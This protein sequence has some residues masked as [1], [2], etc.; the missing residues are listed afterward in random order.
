MGIQLANAARLAMEALARVFEPPPPVDYLAWAE[1][2]IVFSERESPFPGP[3]NVSLFPHVTEILKALSPD[4]PCRVV[5]LEGSAQIGKTAIANIFIGGSMAMD[6]CDFLVVH[7]T[8]DNAGRW[9]KLKLSPLLKGTPV[10][11][12]LFPEKSRD[13]SNS[14]LMKEHRDGLGAIL[15]SGANSPSSLSQVTMR[16]QVQDDLSKWEMNA[17]GDPESQADSRSRAHEF[18]KIL[19]ASTPLILPGCRITKSFESGSQEYP[20]V[21]CPH[22][23]HM[24]VLEWENMHAA[25]DPEKP[26]E[27]HFSCV[28]CGASI[29]EHHRRQMFASLEF[30]AH[31]PAAKREHRSFWIWSAYSFLQSFER[32]AREWLKAKGDPQSEKTFLNDTAGQAYKAASEAPPWEKLRDRAAASDYVRGK[33]PAGAL[34]LFFGFDCQ[35]DRVEGQLVAFGRD[36]R[37]FV[38]DYFVIPGH[39]SDATCQERLTALLDQTW[40][41]ASGQKIGVDL[42]AI[43]GNA[44]TE[45]VW[46]FAKKHG[47]NKLIMVRGLGTDSAPLLA[48]IRK[49]RNQRTGKLLKYAKRFYNFGT[50]VVKMALYRNLAKDDA[51]SNGYIAFPSGLD[52]EYFRQL[53]AERRTPEKRHGFIVY[54]WTKDETQANEGLDTM[55]YAEAASVK[56]GVRGLPDAIWARIEAERETP[57][58]DAQ[59]ELFDTPLFVDPIPSGEMPTRPPQRPNPKPTAGPRFKRL[60]SQMD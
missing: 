18:A 16:R 8:D 41:N 2:N 40:V 26:E 24:Q 23:E 35:H 45:D 13:G 6:P 42:A 30:R 54:R 29:E 56:Y 50:S 28:S 3:F 49:E 51:L 9:S 52:D 47:A 48:R 7:P 36:H 32:I 43:D 34:L 38:I 37:R 25:L 27:A 19:K 20:Y 15:I 58:R 60:S 14:V 22:C 1:D 10:L 31:N 46:D 39:V 11:R 5:T 33:I 4:D 55:L 17:A 53:T 57:P 44:W 59:A 21:P 12:D